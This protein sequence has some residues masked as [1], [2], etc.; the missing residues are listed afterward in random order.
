MSG[1]LQDDR[2]CNELISVV[3]YIISRLS[4]LPIP[5][6]IRLVN[7]Y[8][9]VLPLTKPWESTKLGWIIFSWR[10]AV[11]FRVKNISFTGYR[12]IWIEWKRSSGKWTPDY[13]RSIQQPNI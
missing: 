11:R 7:R 9:T 3:L 6:I 10:R 8:P 12:G 4:G 1:H 5:R 13:N 2:T